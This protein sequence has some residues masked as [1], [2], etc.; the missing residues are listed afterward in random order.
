MRDNLLTSAEMPTTYVYNGST[1]TIK[2]GTT[3]RGYFN[4][5]DAV[6]TNLSDWAEA[7]L[8]YFLNTE[9]D[10]N[11]T[12]GYYASFTDI[13]KK[14]IDNH[15]SYPIGR[16]TYG[17]SA[18]G[19]T[20][21][22]AYSYERSSSNVLSGS[23]FDWEGSVV[24]LYPSD[25][26]YSVDSSYWSDTKLR[27]YDAAAYQTSWMQNS[28]DH[29]SFNYY[30]WVISPG[31]GDPNSVG[32]WYRTYLH[33]DYRADGNSNGN[34]NGI[35]PVLN[36]KASALFE[37]G[38][39][40]TESNPYVIVES[41]D[42]PVETAS[43]KIASKYKTDSTIVAVN[44]DGTLYNGVGEIREY[45]YS[46]ATAN[47]YIVFNDDGDATREANELW[48]I[49]GIFK[50]QD[51]EWNL[52]LMRN[53]VFTSD[54]L[55]ATYN[56]NGSTYTIKNGTTRKGYWNKTDIVKTHLNDWNEAGLN[57]FF[58]TNEDHF[59]IAGY[60]STFTPAAK[61]LIDVNY[62]YY[63][64]RVTYRTGTG[65]STAVLAYSYE[66]DS[67]RV[68]PGSDFVWKGAISLLYPSDY[69]YSAD[70][71]YWSSTLLY[72]YSSAA[73][74]TSWMQTSTDHSEHGGYEWMLSP[75][76]S[77]YDS[78]GLWY[79]NYVNTDNRVDGN[80]SGGGNFIRPVLNLKAKATIKVTGD[81]TIDNPYVVVE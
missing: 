13:A 67:S 10:T 12:A 21:I 62:N 70:S 48:R 54:E 11:G 71:S 58:N 34:G 38:G 41:I 74:N 51:N 18:A 7:G 40:G 37:E 47:N 22:T 27:N 28:T 14:I 17:T 59:G 24:L 3:R 46:G 77:D 15:Y 69:G 43:E 42:P 33:D 20:A 39:T 63:L 53:T 49:V 8:Q 80:T 19:A 64:G 4:K 16:M 25:Y 50:N 44:T 57:F 2:D 6:K 66:R 29:T 55:P 31:S 65:A 30:E 32:L 68:L 76:D 81:G 36:L 61:L 35:R 78:A 52:K 72:N 60:Y 56:Y 73:Y 26:G 45:R 23:T 75:S 1:Y 79:K 5:P 9:K